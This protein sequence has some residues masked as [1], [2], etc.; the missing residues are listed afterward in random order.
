MME[1]FGIIRRRNHKLVSLDQEC[2]SLRGRVAF[3]EE[4]YSRILNEIR[5]GRER[6]NMRFAHISNAGFALR[7]SHD[8]AGDQLARV[9]P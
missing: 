2:D 5:D 3:L 7:S 8:L 9:W 4:Q 6:N 1:L